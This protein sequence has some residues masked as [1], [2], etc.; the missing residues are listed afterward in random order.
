MLRH[1]DR[2]GRRLAK[3]LEYD[4]AELIEIAHNAI[5]RSTIH[6]APKLVPQIEN[7]RYELFDLPNLEELSLF[8]KPPMA[9]SRAVKDLIQV[10]IFRRPIEVKSKIA[11]EKVALIRLAV[12]EAL[13]ELLNVDP[14]VFSGD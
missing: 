10:S 3:S 6:K 5:L 13:A 2:H 12:G 11:Q 1:R 9:D 4:W 8:K 7:I 14:K